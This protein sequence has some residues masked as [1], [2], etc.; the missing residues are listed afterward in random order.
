[1]ADFDVYRQLMATYY[2]QA[3]HLGYYFDAP[4]LARQYDLVYTTE[5][6]WL[7]DLAVAMQEM[8]R[9]KRVLEMASG[10]GRWTRYLAE[11]ASFVLATDASERML[12]QARQMVR[13]GRMLPAKRC[14][15]LRVDAF[16]V[17][18]APGAFDCAV[19]VNFFQHV[20]TRRQALFLD[21]LHRKLGAGA[22]VLIAVNRLHRRTRAL[23]YQ[24]PGET[25]W[26]DLRQ[27]RDGSV[28]EI[29]DNPFDERRMRELLEG[30]GEDLSIRRGAK[31][32]WV[33]YRVG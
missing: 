17:E 9:G 33:R 14:G 12:D 13:V 26:F 21:V 32:D 3:S 7:R 20:P 8:V 23:F 24:K 4:E 15:F 2:D 18:R 25:D 6:S 27:L 19:A 28:Y 22:D 16:E 30:R 10:H 1:M 29:I 31:F 5:G 11:A